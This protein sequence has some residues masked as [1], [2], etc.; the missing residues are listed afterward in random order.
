MVL[1][2][3]AGCGEMARPATFVTADMLVCKWIKY[4][5][6]KHLKNRKYCLVYSR[7]S[8]ARFLV[9]HGGCRPP[10]AEHGKALL[11][12]NLHIHLHLLNQSKTCQITNG[13]KVHVK[14]SESQQRSRKC[15]IKVGLVKGAG[16]TTR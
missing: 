16:D 1:L 9:S 10:A 13:H 14:K 4:K 8:E 7:L 15:D 6:K 12:K 11:L 5:G 2:P 3:A